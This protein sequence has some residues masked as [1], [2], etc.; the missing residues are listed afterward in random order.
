MAGSFA[1]RQSK[2]RAHRMAARRKSDRRR[3]DLCAGG[4]R[5]P[6]HLTLYIGVRCGRGSEAKGGATKSARIKNSAHSGRSTRT[7]MQPVS[8]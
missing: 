4:L 7:N 2:T 8:E 1:I 3:D 6:P 5:R